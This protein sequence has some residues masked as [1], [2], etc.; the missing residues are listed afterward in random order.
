[1]IN[2]RLHIAGCVLGAVVA[3]YILL[4]A[5][6][7]SGRPKLDRYTT[8]LVNTGSDCYANSTFQALSALEHLAAW[9]ADRAGPG[10]WT[11]ALG[12]ALGELRVEGAY[13]RARSI[14]PLLRVMEGVLGAQLGR[15]Q[16]DAHELL[17]YALDLLETE[18]G[19]LPFAFKTADTVRCLACGHAS[20]TE[21]DSLVLERQPGEAIMAPQSEI[22]DGFR[23]EACGRLTQIAKSSRLTELP[24]VLAVHINRST[25]AGESFRNNG[26]TDVPLRLGA[27]ALRAVVFHH[28]GHTRGH[29]TCARRRARGWWLISDDDVREA[30]DAQIR[31]RTTEA[32]LLFFERDQVASSVAQN[33][34]LAN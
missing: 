6:F 18:G 17:V 5:V 22:V 31:G 20:T 27:F 33:V 3:G 10:P 13:P 11:Q 28:G 1:M 24:D 8:G 12:E 21:R 32:Y 4:P 34:K 30:S 19:R 15:G 16:Q 26:A 9:L 25:F 29:Y 7:G 2:D 14:W 23:C